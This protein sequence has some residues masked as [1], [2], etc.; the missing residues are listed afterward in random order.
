MYLL[1][2]Q[3]DCCCYPYILIP[4]GMDRKK[5]K[6]EAYRVH[7]TAHRVSQKSIGL[8][9][10]IWKYYTDHEFRWKE[11]RLAFTSEIKFYK[12]RNCYINFD[13]FSDLLAFGYLNMCTIEEA[14]NFMLLL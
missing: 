4:S 2:I 13:A 6:L 3:S 14:K 9:K 11:E 7:D 10:W 8:L 5:L 12:S 1:H